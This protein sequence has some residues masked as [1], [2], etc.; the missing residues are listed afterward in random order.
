MGIGG[1]VKFLYIALCMSLVMPAMAQQEPEAPQSAVQEASIQWWTISL[2]ATMLSAVGTT[3]FGTRAA[4]TAS[5]ASQQTSESKYDDLANDARFYEDGA[6][7]GLAVTGALAITT[8]TL[9]V[10][11][12]PGTNQKVS[13][14]AT[15]NGLQLL[16]SW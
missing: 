9:Y 2:M 10:I 12:R 14:A 4:L 13:I 6:N 11:E 7:I 8:I 3:Y 15:H 16:S 5:E 1:F